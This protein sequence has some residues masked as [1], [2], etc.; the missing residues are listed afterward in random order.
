MNIVTKIRLPREIAK[1]YL[2]GC[3]LCLLSYSWLTKNPFFAGLHILMRAIPDG[4]VDAGRRLRRYWYRESRC[5]VR[6]GWQKLCALCGY[7]SL[8]ICVICGYFFVP[9]RLYNCKEFFTN[10]PFL[11]NKA[12]FRK[13]QM[14]ATNL[15][16]RDYEKR[17]LGEHGKNEPKRTQFILA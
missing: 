2:M 15:L 9:I 8:K 16:T 13:S 7:K 6:I 1:R 11:T 10:S 14:N 3:N 12:N 4:P 5:Q 17:T